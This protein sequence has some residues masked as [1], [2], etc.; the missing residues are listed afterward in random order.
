MGRMTRRQFIKQAGAA[1]AAAAFPLVF[2]RRTEA[3]WSSGSPVHPNVDDLRVVGLADD[4]MTRPGIPGTWSGQEA[5]V[6]REAV[7]DNLD[8]LACA[9]AL[10]QPPRDAWRSLFVKP[11]GKPWA[12][13]TVAVKT[14][15][16]GRQ[17]TR[18]AVLSRLCH[19]LVEDV[20][21]RPSSIHIYDACHGSGMAGETPFSHLPAGVRV[22]D[23]WG[24]SSRRTRI[25]SLWPG[26]GTSNCLEP[27]VDGSVDIL[28][29]IAMCKGHSRRFGGFTMTMKNHFGTFSPG[30]GHGHAGFEYLLAINQTPE[31]L[32]RLDS[33]NGRVVLPR[34]QLCI[35]DA[36]WASEDGPGCRPQ[37]QPNFLAM[38][39]FSPVVD[40]VVAKEFRAGRMGWSINDEAADRMLRAF[41]V[42]KSDLPEN[43]RII[44]P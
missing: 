13:T 2:A 31:I 36:L 16:I 23:D 29:N 35:V 14:N 19:A 17:H 5:L 3:A 4:A 34:Q 20:G 26:S 27:L 32:G 9:L 25:P 11:P 22:E 39:V 44:E 37:A 41:G 40:Y 1:G 6:N 21:V 7:W 38:G 33:R 30:P 28:V 15:H 43:G 8:R 42:S 24:G 18:S 10:T 12:E